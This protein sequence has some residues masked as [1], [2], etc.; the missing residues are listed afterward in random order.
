[1]ISIRWQK[2]G[3]LSEIT[4]VFQGLVEEVRIYCGI[5]LEGKQ[6]G[7]PVKTI[8]GDARVNTPAFIIQNQI[9]FLKLFSVRIK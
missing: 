1:M 6:L 7:Q 5:F 8:C 2:R 4:T 3:I 9:V